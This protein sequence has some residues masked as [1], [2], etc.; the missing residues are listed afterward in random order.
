MSE[1]SP[2]LSLP[3]IQPSQAQKHL[4]HNEA[5][6]RLDKLVQLVVENLTTNSPPSNVALGTCYVIGPAPTGDW[7]GRAGQLAVSCEGGWDYIVPQDGWQCFDRTTRHT[8]FFDGS[9]WTNA[10]ST[11]TLSLNA[12]TDDTTKFAAETNVA[13]WTAQDS[14][15]GGSG[16]LIHTFNK[17]AETNDSGILFQSSYKTFAVLGAFG[18]ENLRLS[19]SGNGDDFKDAMT[20]DRDTGIVSH[21]SLPRFVATANYDI[22]GAKN[23]WLKLGI[24]LA[25]YNDQNCFD[26]ENS[27]FTAPSDGTYMIGGS[28]VFKIDGTTGTRMN[29]QLRINDILHPPSTKEM[30]T[31]HVNHLTGLSIQH[32]IPLQA[33]DRVTLWGRYRANSG[34]FAANKT[35]FWGYK[36]G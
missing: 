26:A 5:I 24:N 16:D 32:L 12:P 10:V 30:S 23:T 22:Y 34:Y 7:E 25:L 20:V 18:T 36:V 31:G 35:E 3:Y 17:Q 2:R 6:D 21:P 9:I 33:G 15:T 14:D 19:V 4:T 28:T 11:S 29:L 8:Y 1:F 27:W 13:L